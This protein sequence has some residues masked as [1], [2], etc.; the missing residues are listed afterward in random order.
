MG[1]DQL[2]ST[3]TFNIQNEII[4]KHVKVK[5]PDYD[6]RDIAKAFINGNK[7]ECV[8][9]YPKG[10]VMEI[11][12]R[13]GPN[14]LHHMYK[15]Q[16]PYSLLPTLDEE[17]D[18]ETTKIIPDEDE[19]PP[20]TKSRWAKGYSPTLRAPDG[21]I[22]M[23]TNQ[24]IDE[25]HEHGQLH[26]QSPQVLQQMGTSNDNTPICEHCRMSMC[27]WSSNQVNLKKDNELMK[28]DASNKQK[29]FFAYKQM[30]FLIH[31]PLS[32]G[33]RQQL[34]ECVVDGIRVAWPENDDKYTSFRESKYK[35]IAHCRRLV[36]VV[37]VLVVGLG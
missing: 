32:K 12:A 10:C 28:G 20:E 30:T 37:I 18:L 33:D 25:C 29:R 19:L 35:K 15:W 23:I 34:P 16:V 21:S 9:R 7:V 11:Q 24:L 22:E 1:L 5:V 36:G 3:W 8:H 6:P 14:E 31:G 17:L 2:P 27:L 4:N 26:Y 13:I